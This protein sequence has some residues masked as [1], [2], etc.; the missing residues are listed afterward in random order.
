LVRVRNPEIVEI[1]SVYA[2]HW[3]AEGWLNFPSR[4]FGQLFQEAAL[5]AG[6]MFQIAGSSITGSLCSRLQT[7]PLGQEECL[8]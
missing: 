2:P 8:H 5:D 3:R 6:A 4:K 7:C 1:G